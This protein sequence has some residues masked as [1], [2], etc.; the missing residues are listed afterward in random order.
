MKH[1]ETYEADNFSVD[2]AAD[3]FARKI[4]ASAWPDGEVGDDVVSF[5][6]KA[7]KAFHRGL[8]REL[9]TQAQSERTSP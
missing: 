6:L 7:A 8:V 2:L 4:S 1:Y 3:I 9:D 5:A